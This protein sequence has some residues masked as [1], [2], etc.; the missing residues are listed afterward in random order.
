MTVKLLWYNLYCKKRYI[1]KGDL[2]VNTN[3]L[4]I[5]HQDFRDSE[6][7]LG[8]SQVFQECHYDVV[9][10]DLQPSRFYSVCC[11]VGF[12]VSAHGRVPVAQVSLSLS[13]CVCVCVRSLP[14]RYV[15][16]A[17]LLLSAWMNAWEKS[18]VRALLGAFRRHVWDVSPSVSPKLL[19]AVVC[20]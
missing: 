3:C 4:C 14:V 19:L 18:E 7:K 13:L 10:V 17:W 20:M 12:D 15:T 8:F 2:T 1:N 6:W 16:A 9:I 5:K 11:E